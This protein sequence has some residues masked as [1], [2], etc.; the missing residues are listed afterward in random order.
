ML[1]WTHTSRRLCGG[2]HGAYCWRSA[3]VR[4]NSYG[5]PK[6]D[7]DQVAIRVTD[8]GADLAAVILWL[9]EELRA[10]GQPLLVHPG[11]IRDADVEERAR[12]VGVGRRRQCDR[13][14]VVS[15]TAANIEDEP[16]I[17][18]LHDHRVTF[19]DNLPIE[20]RSVELPG[21]V[22]IGDDKKMRQN[23]TSRR[24]WEVVLVH[25]KPLNS[26]A[27]MLPEMP[28]GATTSRCAAH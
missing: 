23:E 17:G 16:R 5:E 18:D 4:T 24:R 15:W 3:R 20:Q 1:T 12:A 2:S 13:R 14:F 8:V 6:A 28:R 9:G 25:A 11:D 19:H 26:A 10:L 7:L 22:L 27:L 21:A